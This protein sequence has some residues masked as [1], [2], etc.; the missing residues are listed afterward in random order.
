MAPI[1][2]VARAAV[3]VSP[4]AE[5]RMRLPIRDSADARDV[6]RRCAPPIDAPRIA[7]AHACCSA[8]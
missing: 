2:R 1:A 8:A 6:E 7:C 5:P 3:R 4:A